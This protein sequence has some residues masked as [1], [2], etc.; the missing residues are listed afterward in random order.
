[1]HISKMSYLEYIEVYCHEVVFPFS[2][3]KPLSMSWGELFSHQLFLPGT[4]QIVVPIPFRSPLK[5][6]NRLGGFYWNST[7]IFLAKPQPT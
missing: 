6:A 3:C 1:M 7:I 4:Y 5:M 2:L